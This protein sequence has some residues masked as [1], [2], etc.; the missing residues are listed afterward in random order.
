MMEAA[1]HCS[2]DVIQRDEG[3]APVGQIDEPFLVTIC[4]MET[5]VY[6][7]T[8]AIPG[9][10][11]PIYCQYNGWKPLKQPKKVKNQTG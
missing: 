4:R 11:K 7:P 5:T 10:N 6:D 3:E 8:Q 2:P 1:D 9:D